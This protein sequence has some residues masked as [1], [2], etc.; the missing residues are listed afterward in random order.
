VVHIET[1][2]PPAKALSGFILVWAPTS[3]VPCVR[4]GSRSGNELLST[5]RCPD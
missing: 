3:V 1:A 5:G 4:A 2:H